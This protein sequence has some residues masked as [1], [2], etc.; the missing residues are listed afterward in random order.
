VAVHVQKKNPDQTYKQRN[1][2]LLNDGKGKF[3]EDRKALPTDNM[4]VHRGASF[5]DVNNDG[6]VDILVTAMDDRPTLLINES[7][8][9]GNW[10]LLKLTAKNGCATPIGAR[11]IATVNGKKHLRVL[12]GGGSYAS[13]SDHRVHFGLG[14]ASTIEK[15]EIRW[16]SGTTQTLNNVSANQILSVREATS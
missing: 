11:C 8:N 5:G 16:P 12:L 3:D 9:S 7:T 4:R 6:R 13:E 14:A 15:L 10:L 1:Q 2:L